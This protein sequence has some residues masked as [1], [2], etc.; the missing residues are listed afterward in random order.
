MLQYSENNDLLLE[1]SGEKDKHVSNSLH[2]L[3]KLIVYKFCE[4]QKTS[5]FVESFQISFFNN[6]FH[7]TF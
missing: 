1:K 6:G 4:W 2:H 5:I 7:V 3:C